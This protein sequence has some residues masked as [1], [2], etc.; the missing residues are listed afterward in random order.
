MRTRVYTASTSSDTDLFR[1]FNVLPIVTADIEMAANGVA[2]VDWKA[3]VRH[4]NL[5]DGVVMYAGRVIYKVAETQAGL[6]TATWTDVPKAVGGG[7]ILSITDHYGNIVAKGA[8]PL[9]AGLWY[10]FG[11][12]GCSASSLAPNTDGLCELSNG[13]GDNPYNNMV[14]TVI[15]GATLN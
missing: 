14:V 12:K 5:V 11:A 3:E 9:T 4:R 2:T 8:I 13:P 10:R 7:N 1:T 15:E 6:A